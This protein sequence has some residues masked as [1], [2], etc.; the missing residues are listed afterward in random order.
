MKQMLGSDFAASACW[1][2]DGDEQPSKYVR[3]KIKEL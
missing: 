2:G 1:G 3:E